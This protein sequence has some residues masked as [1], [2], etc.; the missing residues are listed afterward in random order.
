MGLK[1]NFNKLVRAI[2]LIVMTQREKIIKRNEMEIRDLDKGYMEISIG[3]G[4]NRVV[5]QYVPLK[6]SEAQ[7]MKERLIKLN[8]HNQARIDKVKMKYN[9][10]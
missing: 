2:D 5:S 9:L 3:Y 6:P 10:D 1:D 4:F 8:E 7:E